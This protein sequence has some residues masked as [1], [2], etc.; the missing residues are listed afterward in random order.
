MNAV[1]G[2][3]QMLLKLVEETDADHIAVIFDRARKTFRSDIYPEYKAHRPPPP[4]DLV[5]QFELVRQATR[6]MNIPAVDM[7][8]FEADDL[9]ATYARQGAEMGAEVTIVST[10]KDLMQMV[11]GKIKMFDAMKNKSIGPAEVEEK[12][13][14]G[15][16]KVIDI[17]ALAGD[18]SDN[19]PGVQGIGIK[20]AA[21]LINEYGDLDGVLENAGKIKQPKRRE[22]LI[23]QADLARISRDLVT[24]RQDVPVESNIEDFAVR[25]IEP[26][27]LLIFLQEQG[28]KSLVTRIESQTGVTAPEPGPMEQTATADQ[29]SGDA[30]PSAV[31]SG[32]IKAAA[33]SE[34]VYELVQDE[35]ALHKWIA[36]AC[37]DGVLAVDTETTSLDSMEANLVGISLCTVPGH[38]CYIP[39]AHAAPEE[40]ASLDL[41]ETDDS[42]TKNNRTIK[43]ISLKS[44]VKVLKPLLESPSVLKIGHNI[45][46]DQKILH[47]YGIDVTPVDDTMI[48]SYVLE[49]AKHGHGMDELS[50][51]YLDHQTIKFKDVAGSGKS[52]VT[53]DRV[54]L[55]KALNYAAEDADITRRL[56]QVLK[57]RLVTDQVTTIYETLE[58]PLIYV[59]R[60][61]ETTGIRVDSAF[62]KT[63]SADFARRLGDLEIAIHKLAGKEFNIGSPK[64]L[65]EVLF[66]EMGLTGGKKTKTGAYG[67]GA[68]V[69]EGLAAEGHELPEQVLA[70]RQLAKLKST[71]TDTLVDQIN[72]ETGRV[73]TNYGQAIASTGRLSSNDPNLQNI[74]IRTEEGRKI[75]QAFIPS[76]G[77]VLVSADY[78]QIEL[79]L[80]AH[81]ADIDALKRAFHDGMDIHALTASQVFGVPVEGMDPMIRR[82][83]KAI[84]FGIIYGIS[85]FGLARQLSISRGEASD[86]IQAYFE[87][88]PGIRDFMEHAKETAREKGYVTTLY[89]RKCFVPGIND[90][91]PNR[92]NFMERAAI[93]AP[94]QGG[95]ADIIKRAMIQ[96]PRA[97]KTS[98]LS[99]KM[100]LQVHDELI[101]DVPKK[102]LEDTVEVVKNI[103]E[104]AADLSVPIVVDTG[105]GKNWDEAH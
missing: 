4:D 50:L 56:F 7:D 8:G 53:F 91:N 101:F 103:M 86:Y 40:Q 100:L 61:M 32:A 9:I 79:R 65:G 30:N 3:T 89:G 1:Y 20:T 72:P 31:N 84:N 92:R 34:T 5:P 68:D 83:A 36:A 35:A 93:N 96:L 87:K 13:G 64:Q 17:Q 67:T 57:P 11:G 42:K 54:P 104:R 66:E 2:F 28:F 23:E 95:A 75:R 73:H 41:G 22:A 88:Y 60:D 99:A 18:S 14:V 63:L 49:G 43:Q 90:K 24:L 19:V 97:L 51:L 47:R 38:A 81:V 70:W 78:S 55:D 52:Q 21:I 16:D 98:K 25:K 12:F 102:E 77:H 45:K 105:H 85:A 39:I 10:D 58:R 71:Y 59:L 80:L 69:L 62:L 94:I 82:Q 74:P 44:V 48:L 15:P 6:A 46:Y 37:A 29:K 26:D 27:K 76:E 33:V